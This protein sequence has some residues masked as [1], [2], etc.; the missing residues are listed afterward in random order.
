MPFPSVCTR[1]S[2][3]Y[4]L[5]FKLTFEL[6]IIII[7]IARVYSPLQGSEP[8]VDYTHLSSVYLL[9]LRLVNIRTLQTLRRAMAEVVRQNLKIR[10]ICYERPAPPLRPCRPVDPTNLLIPLAPFPTL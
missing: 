4:F 1:I 7:I 10:A 3:S 2:I 8:Y 6:I 5:I 9:D